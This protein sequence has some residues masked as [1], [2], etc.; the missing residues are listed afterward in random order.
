MLIIDNLT[1][2]YGKA[3][4]LKDLTLHIEST[5]IH[6]LLGLNGAGKTTLLN[7]IYGIKKS[8]NGSIRY[9][10]NPI[11]RNEIS[12]LETNNYFYPRITGQE[13]L[14]LIKSKAPDFNTEEW[15]QLFG[16]PLNKLIDTYSNGMKKKLALFGIICI[17]KP[18]MLLD[19]PFNGLDLETIQKIK[20]LLVQLKSRGKTI[21]ITSHILESLFSI[22]ESISYINKSN[23]Q[24][25]KSSK[26]F[27]KIEKEIFELHQ[28]KINSKINSL[29]GNP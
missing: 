22:C 7:T 19:E 28:D 26:E 16:L 9:N 8:L 18:I 10:N 15:N 24:F 23:I 6:G 2:N 1:V 5:S 12:F 11:S 17:N 25:T 20:A 4:V 14:N 27:N 21:I 3:I 29:L 13:F